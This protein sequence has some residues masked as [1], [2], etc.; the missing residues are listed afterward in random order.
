[1]PRKPSKRR[2]AKRQLTPA[3]FAYLTDGEVVGEEAE[4]DLWCLG[5]GMSPY[6]SDVK[7]QE[8]WEKYRDDFLPRFITT[9]PGRRPLP[10]WQW[11]GPKRDT[12]TGAF[13]EPLP[14]PRRRIGGKGQTTW[15]RYP[16]V[17]PTY[18]K[19]VPSAWDSVDKGD[20]PRFES[21]A[22]YLER[23]GLLTDAERKYLAVHRELLEPEKINP[24]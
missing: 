15:E 23:H 11:D 22:R 18:K 3:E 7:P 16:A 12:G 1:M 4:A 6:F 17:M 20:P 13:F 24:T 9:N 14:E 10:W 8:L 5:I 21:E 2:K 19:G